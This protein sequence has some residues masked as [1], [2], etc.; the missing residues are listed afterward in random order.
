VANL[1]KQP[2]N[3][4]R[5]AQNVFG[6]FVKQHQKSYIMETNYNSIEENYNAD[7]D[8]DN[9]IRINNSE[10]DSEDFDYD[11][12]YDPNEMYFALLNDGNN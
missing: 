7:S 2:Y 5:H 3:S 9:I 12:D 11:F 10:D 1:I 8:M 6:N 4:V